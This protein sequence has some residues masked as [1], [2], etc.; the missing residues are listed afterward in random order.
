MLWIYIQMRDR[1]CFC[2]RI[3]AASL[4]GLKLWLEGLSITAFG[5]TPPFVPY[6]NFSSNSIAF[7]RYC[8]RRAGWQESG[9]TDAIAFPSNT[10]RWPYFPFS[11]ARRGQDRIQRVTCQRKSNEGC[12][13]KVEFNW[14]NAFSSRIHPGSVGRCCW[15]HNSM[16]AVVLWVIIIITHS[17]QPSSQEQETMEIIIKTFRGTAEECMKCVLWLFEDLQ[18]C[19]AAVS[20]AWVWILRERD[21]AIWQWPSPLS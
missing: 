9:G 18:L 7:L 21:F 3:Q 2:R 6:S 17:Q 14:I 12:F 10:V 4:L 13:W 5:R 19:V 16:T 15:W 1:L 11:V 8:W 20:P